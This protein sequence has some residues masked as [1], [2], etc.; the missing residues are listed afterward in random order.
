MSKRK[1][2]LRNPSVVHVAAAL[3]SGSGAHVDKK[4]QQNKKACRGQVKETEK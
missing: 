3:H 1:K 4:K 2:K